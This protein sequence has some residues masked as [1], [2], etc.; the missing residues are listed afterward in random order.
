MIALKTDIDMPLIVKDVVPE[1]AGKWHAGIPMDDYHAD[2]E[3]LSRS[4]ILIG[5]KSPAHFLAQWGLPEKDKAAF[6]IG[7]LTD[8]AVYARDQYKRTVFAEPVFEHDGRTKDGKK[9]R[10]DYAA[11]LPKD[12]IVI[13]GDEKRMI[14][15]MAESVLAHPLVRELLTEGDSQLSGWWVD[16]DTGILCRCRPDWRAPKRRII[17]DLKTCRDASKDGFARAIVNLGYDVQ[18]GHYLDGANAIDGAGSYDAWLFVA[19][20]KEP[21]YPCAVYVADEAMLAHGR[22]IRSRVMRQLRQCIETGDF[23][24]YGTEA[25]TISLPTWALT[26]AEDFSL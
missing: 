5:N 22:A 8:D 9:E 18:A 4:G 12:A 11:S 20:E 7:R 1:R 13:D 17:K 21:P 19:V 23:P 15:A 10:A 2:Y 24:A 16:K 25:Q 3:A 26:S 6:R 14:D